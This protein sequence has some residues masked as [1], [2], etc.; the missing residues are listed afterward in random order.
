MF[1]RLINSFG[2]PANSYGDAELQLAAS[3]L[4]FAV[5]PVDY[6]VTNEE[7]HALRNSLTSLFHVSPEKCRRMISRAA[8][9]HAKEPSF[10]AAAT[11]LKHRT[12]ESF[13]Q[14]LMT[15]ARNLSRADG[16]VH[17]NELDLEQR[18]E[19]LLGLADQALQQSA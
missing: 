7:A 6:K 8:A 14:K 16:V 15:E 11:L 10:V 18:L 13:R 12:T 1:E 9:A 3:K 4:L 5:L 19:R 17:N 2:Q